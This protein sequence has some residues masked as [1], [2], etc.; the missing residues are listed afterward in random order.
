MS[1]Q[2]PE[3]P[4][5]TRGYSVALLSSVILSTTAIFIRYL[6]ETY[7]MPAVVLAFWRDAFV[8]LTLLLVLGLLRPGLLKAGRRF[9]AYLLGYGVVLALF[10][11]LWTLSVAL[12][13]AS[14]ATVLVYSSAAF[15]AILGWQFLKESLDGTKV[16]AII[17]SLTGCALVVNAFA[18]S[19][20]ETNISG[21]LI[22]LAAGLG[23]AV[24]TLM[25][26]SASQ[27]GLNPWTTVLYTFGV[28]AGVLFLISLI[29]VRLFP[30]TA[31]GPEA[32]FWLGDAWAGWA[33]LI[34]LAAGPTL[35]GFGLY[36]VSLVYLPSSVANLILTSEPAFTVIIAYLLLGERLSWP[37]VAGSL[38]ILGG[39]A[40]LRIRDSR[41]ERRLRA[42]PILPE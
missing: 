3:P 8:S 14:I 4:R 28:A 29:P 39:V 18:M 22:G 9:R 6:T 34:L 5:L 7:R 13:G 27:R 31:T 15:T 33:I 37:Q 40:V 11:A 21:I 25:G 2:S 36:N 30:D 1:A 20:W 26:R 12:N 16:L 24:Y 35:A 38:L 23:Y 32:L 42:N 10:N 41:R 17:F 19:S